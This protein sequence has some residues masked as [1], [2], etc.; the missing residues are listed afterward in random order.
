MTVTTPCA[1]TVLSLDSSIHS[2]EYPY[3]YSPNEMCT[4]VVVAPSGRQI[5]IQF[6]DFRLDPSKDNLIIYDGPS[7]NSEMIQ[8]LN[9]T[10]LPADVISTGNS[11]FLRIHIRR[12]NTLQ[13]PV[14]PS[15]LPQRYVILNNLF[16]V[17]PTKWLV[18]GVKCN[19]LCIW[20]LEYA[21]FVK[22]KKRTCRRPLEKSPTMKDAIDKCGDDQDCLVI[23]NNCD[24]AVHGFSLCT[25]PDLIQTT[26]NHCAYF[27]PRTG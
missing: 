12:Q 23:D 3:K 19:L 2:P 25:L 1:N 15:V 8:K 17:H 14:Q 26:D 16:I 20:L 5:Q 10:S 7:K 22:L 21:G 27:K 24:A 11:F 4:W 9:G 6:K 13:W 18:H